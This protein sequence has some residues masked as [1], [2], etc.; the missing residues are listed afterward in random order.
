MNLNTKK[1]GLFEKLVYG[2]GQVGMNVM[3]TL[4]S[5]Y[6]LL[7]YTDVAGISPAMIGGVILASKIFDGISDLIAGQ[8]IDTH[9][10][11]KG[12]CIPVLAR[13]SIPMVFSVVL[14]FMIP[15]SGIAVRLVFAFITY[16]L[17]N[18]VL[19]TYTSMAYGTLPTYVTNDP[20]DR[21]QMMIYAMLFAGVTQTVMASAISP[22]LE[23]FGGMNQQSAW[24]KSCLVFGLIGLIFLLANVWIVKE[25][26]DNPKPPENILSGIKYAVSNKYWWITLAMCMATNVCL[27]FNLSISVY[28]LQNVV[29]NME[30]MGA[31]VACS[32]LP[33]VVLMMIMPLMLKKI[34]K[35]K[36]FIIGCVIMLAANVVFII[37]P[38][39]SVPL[40]LG[41]ALIRGIGFGFPM[42][43]NNAMVADCVDYGEWKHGIRVQSPLF[44]ANSVSQK[45][46]QG[47]L[48]S[49]F[50]FFLTAISY[51]GL[52][53]VQE[54]STIAG[55]NY[56]F[57]WIPLIMT[58]IMIV[59]GLFF[60]LEKKMPQ[61][62]EDLEKRRGSAEV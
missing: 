37:G 62:L 45:V 1:V 20:I 23:F 8:L 17:F 18:T 46:G 51:D 38:S 42:G 30:L 47:L 14:V 43:L 2:S 26:V 28:Y 25:R 57:K 16:N 12:H 24:I 49:L 40:L 7:F 58:I 48:T 10:S 34:S 56:F 50:G 35:Q 44:S 60:D 15:A 13:W 52:K 39:D 3:Y 33:G 22:M 55:I 59:C 31:F 6:V 4:F 54:A 36:M 29:G 27:M 5:S 53:E 11:E 21:S 19:Y 41:T 61:I 9:K 32:N